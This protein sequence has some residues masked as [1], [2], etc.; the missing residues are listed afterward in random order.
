[1]LVALVKEES[2]GYDL[3]LLELRNDFVF[4]SFFTDERNNGLL[5]HFVNSILGGAF[6]HYR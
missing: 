2:A 3:E 4:K 6:S 5:L 1:M